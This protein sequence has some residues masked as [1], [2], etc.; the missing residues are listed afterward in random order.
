VS[1][2]AAESASESEAKPRSPRPEADQATKRQMIDAAVAC[3]L[4][5]GFYRASSNEIA[6][7]A[8]VTWGVIQYHFGTRE[9]LMLAVLE[10]GASRFAELVETAQIEGDT[11]VERL[12]QLLDILVAHYGTPEY[13]AYM[14]ILL[15][16]DHD[17]STSTQVR[18]TL[19]SLAEHS[20]NNVRRLLR[21]ALGPGRAN[22][23]LA[24][25]MFLTLRGFAVSQQ[26]LDTMAYDT[27]ATKTDRAKGQRRLLTQILG[28]YLE[29]S[30]S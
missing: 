28:S 11:A 23:D 25:T 5:R 27:V 21:D 14:Q 29:Q 24:T 1:N 17:P 8:G 18:E 12:E 19:R 2:R 13:L 3:I 22:G 30:S 20:S 26:L 10:D 9:A 6:R 7:R 4:D 15:N 16:M